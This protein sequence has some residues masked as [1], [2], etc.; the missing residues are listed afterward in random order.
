MTL[1][2]KGAPTSEAAEKVARAIGNSLLV[3][4]SWYG[5]DPNWGRIVDAA[6]YAQ[7]GIDIEKV[8]L[9]YDTVPAL[10]QGTPKVENEPEWKQVV[11]NKDFT[12]QLDLNLG[13][14]NYKLLSTDLT[15]AYVDF[16][17]SE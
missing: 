17:R 4:S 11:A 5:S 15:E 3:K 8:D 16:N 2:I 13:D 9:S 1:E 12:I 7:V 14:Y 6:G 10:I